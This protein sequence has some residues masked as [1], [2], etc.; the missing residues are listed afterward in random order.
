M[1]QLSNVVF[2]KI[3]LAPT[4]IEDV[5][6]QIRTIRAVCRHFR[7]LVDQVFSEVMYFAWGRHLRD[8]ETFRCYFLGGHSFDEQALL[9]FS[10]WTAYKTEFKPF[11][12]WYNSYDTPGFPEQLPQ[13]DWIPTPVM[14]DDYEEKWRLG[15][16]QRKRIKL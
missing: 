15:K 12:S 13:F 4:T 8:P 9:E 14:D 2:V 3:L 11:L 7:D 5:E 10:S 1:Y 16:V 6:R